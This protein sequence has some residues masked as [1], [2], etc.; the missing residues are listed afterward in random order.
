VDRPATEITLV[1]GAPVRVVGDPRAVEA[2]ILAAARGSIPELV[3]L[4]E[5]GGDRPVALNPDHVVALRPVAGD[6]RP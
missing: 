3:W 6:D 1:N 2:A 4:T 5:V